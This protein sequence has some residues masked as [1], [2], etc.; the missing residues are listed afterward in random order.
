MCNKHWKTKPKVHA[1]YV[2]LSFLLTT[3]SWIAV[4]NYSKPSIKWFGQ[5]HETS[6]RFN[7]SNALNWKILNRFRFGLANRL[8]PINKVIKNIKAKLKFKE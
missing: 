5:F 1:R 4:V 6:F 2:R 8:R 7:K 3:P